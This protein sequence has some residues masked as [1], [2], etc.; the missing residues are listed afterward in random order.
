MKKKF[1]AH[2]FLLAA[3]LFL[4]Q[5]L[6]AW[7]NQ[8][9]LVPGLPELA[10]ALLELLST[11]EFYQ[12]A[13]ATILRGVAGMFLSL[14][15]AFAAAL[16][17]S[18]AGWIHEMFR[19][20][21]AFMR[22]VPVISFIL[23]AL[24]F[25]HTES[26][27]LLIGFLTMF[28]LLAENIANGLAGIR[29]E[30]SF[31][32]HTFLVERRNRIL[33]VILPQLKPFL[34]S[35]LASAAGFGWRAIIMGEVL[36]Q[37]NLGIGAEMKRAQSLIDPPGVI[38]WTLAAILLSYA[39][40]KAIHH[41]SKRQYHI[42]FGK[43][44]FPQTIIPASIRLQNVS[45]KYAVS[46][47]TYTFEA[48][49]VYGIT[50]PSGTGKTTLLNLINGYF[51]PLKGKVAIDRQQGIAAVFQDPELLP[52]LTVAENIMLVLARLYPEKEAVT[53]ALK[54]LQQV[55]MEEYADRY[56]SELSAGQQQRAAIARALAFPAPCLIMDE[57]FRGLDNALRQRII[58]QIRL[59]QR[60]K[61]QTII[62]T[63]HHQ[64]ELGS[65]AETLIRLHRVES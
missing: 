23:L 29:K 31:M 33:H 17:F 52:N 15:C 19:P 41:L 40:D 24:I 16:L 20:L 46:N 58:E 55:E 30:R 28:P 53:I 4:W 57:P 12:S 7:A 62:F 60:E 22:S 21:L 10:A 59:R 34:F 49:K 2:L 36:A 13:G 25:L 65:L 32:A 6:A 42:R 43:K 5:L 45:Y 35:G 61:S 14:V 37:T 48:A 44:P 63:S 54:T 3:L 9:Y 1:L 50:A 11:P 64:E 26:I 47:Y 18:R 38:A 51:I 8:P 39:S 27:P 56:P